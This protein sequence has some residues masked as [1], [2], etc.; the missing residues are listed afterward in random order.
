[1]AKKDINLVKTFSRNESN[2]PLFIRLFSFAFAVILTTVLVVANAAGVSTTIGTNISTNG[3]LTVNGAS[4]LVSLSLSGGLNAS[5]TLQV[6]GATTLYGS[7]TLTGF[8]FSGPLNASSTLLASGLS[9]FYGGF[10]SSA[11]STISSN[12]TVTGQINSS[13]TISIDGTSGTSTIGSIT[14][15]PDGR[16]GIGTTTPNFANFEVATRTIA[17]NSGADGSLSQ[18]ATATNIIYPRKQAG[19]IVANGYI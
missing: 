10:I 1:M 7:L 15:G 8:T 6:T 13:S 16:I 12:L 2:F 14:I 19:A 17:F 5:S 4:S 11:S 9:T 3:T 18:W